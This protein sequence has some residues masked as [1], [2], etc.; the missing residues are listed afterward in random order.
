MLVTSHDRR[1]VDHIAQRYLLIVGGELREINDPNDFYKGFDAG[2][3]K[4][5]DRG[6]QPAA[7]DTFLDASRENDDS[8]EVKLQHLIDL[9]A[10]LEADLA[11]KVRF[12]KPRWQQQWRTAIEQLTLALE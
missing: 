8:D 7:D 6:R 1:F 12:Q 5:L 4:G 3:P 2:M 11:R 10:L 9:E